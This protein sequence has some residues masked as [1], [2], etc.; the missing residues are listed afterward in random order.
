MSVTE[1]KITDSGNWITLAATPQDKLL[2]AEIAKQDGNAS[3]SATVRRLIRQEAQRRG[4]VVIES[5]EPIS[6]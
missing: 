3:Q 2:L 1:P 5:N 4:I 6:A